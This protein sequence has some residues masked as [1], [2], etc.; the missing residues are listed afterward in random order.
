MAE[1]IYPLA[2]LVLDFFCL[3]L[4][5]RYAASR[6]SPVWIIPT[7]LSLVLLL[8]SVIC[9][10]ATA[11]NI[12]GPVLSSTASY[13]SIFLFVVSAIWILVIIAFGLRMRGKLN[14]A[15]FE[16]AQLLAMRAKDLPQ[17]AV[18]DRPTA[19]KRISKANGLE[20]E[21]SNDPYDNGPV[22]TLMPKRTAR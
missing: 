22:R 16:E 17:S 12:A 18:D 8:G 20:R 19:F 4:C 9:L 13:L 10:L 21:P 1:Y 6:R 14:D 5:I 2:T 7:L 11:S 3:L 15:A